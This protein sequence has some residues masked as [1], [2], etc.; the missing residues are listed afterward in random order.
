MQ[1]LQQYL[2]IK[3]TDIIPLCYRVWRALNTPRG[4]VLV[5]KRL[6]AD[7]TRT[8]ELIFQGQDE[9]LSWAFLSESETHYRIIF[10]QICYFPGKENRMQSSRVKSQSLRLE[11][12][13]CRLYLSE[14]GAVKPSV[15]I[16]SLSVGEWPGA[17]GY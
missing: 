5:K 4:N 10:L 15:L 12:V 8:S 1:V 7:V 6:R 13:I 3:V 2:Q 16:C 14:L 11:A 17:A 9:F